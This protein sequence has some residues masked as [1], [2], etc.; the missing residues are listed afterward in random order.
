[1][2]PDQQ[3]EVAQV[4]ELQLKLKARLDELGFVDD[5][6]SIGNIIHHL[7]ETAVFGKKLSTEIL[8][9]LLNLSIANRQEIGELVVDLQNELSEIKDSLEQMEPALIK[10]MNFL[11]PGNPLFP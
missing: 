9:A 3:T 5:A 4:L 11:L 8:P 10:L 7:A 6:D 2:M 1:M